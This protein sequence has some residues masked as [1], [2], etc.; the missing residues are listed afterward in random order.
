M[1]L[2][3]C[4]PIAVAFREFMVFFTQDPSW[5]PILSFVDAG[6]QR[7]LGRSAL[8]A[9]LAGGCLIGLLLPLGSDTAVKRE[10]PWAGLFLLS[11]VV[12]VALSGR[13]GAAEPEWETWALILLFALLVRRA[14][15][16][17]IHVTALASLYLTSLV[18]FFHALW[19]AVPASAARLGGIFFK[20]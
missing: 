11:G 13:V 9:L 19:I 18:I 20:Y 4:F 16:K 8:R 12:S 1:F 5:G 17:S 2:L 15:P 7:P 14:R 6:A 3:V 10:K